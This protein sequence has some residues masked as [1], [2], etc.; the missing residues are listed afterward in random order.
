[1]VQK[2]QDAREELVRAAL[3]AA[4]QKGLD[5]AATGFLI[6]VPTRTGRLD[7]LGNATTRWDV[8]TA[9]TAARDHCVCRLVTPQ[10][11]SLKRTA[12][13]LQAEPVKNNFLSGSQKSRGRDRASKA[14]GSTSQWINC[15]L[16]SLISH[17]AMASTSQWINCLLGSLTFGFGFNQSVDQ[18]P[19]GI[20]HLIRP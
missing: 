19:A 12:A 13:Q 4:Q 17:S 2:A 14:I 6:V 7:A 11:S 1:M 3:A 15:L 5:Y 18:L 20:T 16:G 10:R 8:C 9:V